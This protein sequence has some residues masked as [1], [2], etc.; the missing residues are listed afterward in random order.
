MPRTVPG[1]I[2][3]TVMKRSIKA[4]S[5]VRGR[6]GAGGRPAAWGAKAC[7]KAASPCSRRTYSVVRDTP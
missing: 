7:R 2:G 5:T 3:S 1:V 6:L 4:A